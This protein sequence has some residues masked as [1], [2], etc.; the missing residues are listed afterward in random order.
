MQSLDV[1]EINLPKTE[2]G[3][4]TTEVQELL[5]SSLNLAEDEED[6][7]FSIPQRNSV[8]SVKLVHPRFSD[9]SKKINKI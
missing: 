7:Q 8:H 1:S 2:D 3:Y 4:A 6:I 5:I 9:H